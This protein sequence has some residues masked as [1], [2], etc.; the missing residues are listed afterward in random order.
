MEFI[1]KMAVLVALGIIYKLF[2]HWIKA[3]GIKTAY[4]KK[5]IKEYEE[6]NL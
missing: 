2:E 1:A 4:E 6:D 3:K 5:I